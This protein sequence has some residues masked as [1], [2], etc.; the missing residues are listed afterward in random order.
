MTS[1]TTRTITT[2]A[3]TAPALDSPSVDGSADDVAGSMAG[4]VALTTGRETC[5]SVLDQQLIPYIRILPQKLK[6][7][8][9]KTEFLCV[10]LRRNTLTRMSLPAARVLRSLPPAVPTSTVMVYSVVGSRSSITTLESLVLTV[11][12]VLIARATCPTWTEEGWYVTKYTGNPLASWRV[13]GV[14]LTRAALLLFTLST[15]T[16]LTWAV[17]AECA[18]VRQLS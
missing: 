10:I 18:K 12:T 5:T 16:L 8:D 7:A 6:H 4:S 17:G 2:A 1:R 13:S 11:L 3:A 9:K 15:F 14:Q